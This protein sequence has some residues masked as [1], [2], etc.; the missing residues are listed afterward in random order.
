MHVQPHSVINY[1]STQ[2]Y[3]AYTQSKKRH[4]A[5]QITS[6]SQWNWWI[7]PLLLFWKLRVMLNNVQ[8][9]LA[10]GNVFVLRMSC[11]NGT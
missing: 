6:A 7:T 1:M 2:A 11:N 8:L 5:W 4:E 9:A 10:M 3:T